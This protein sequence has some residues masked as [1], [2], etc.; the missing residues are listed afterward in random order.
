MLG[1]LLARA[2]VD[3]T[4]LSASGSIPRERRMVGATCEVATGVFEHTE[5]LPGLE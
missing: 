3:G 4:D 5:A 2:G 1:I